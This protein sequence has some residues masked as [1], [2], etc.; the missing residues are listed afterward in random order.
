MPD[1]DPRYDGMLPHCLR[2]DG[3]SSPVKFRIALRAELRN[4]E[5]AP[6]HL[7]LGAVEFVLLMLRELEASR[8]PEQPTSNNSSQESQPALER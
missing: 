5:E 6:N 7:A 3:I 8:A 4:L 2:D 1:I